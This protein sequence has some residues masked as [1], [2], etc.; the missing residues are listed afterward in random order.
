VSNPN[1]SAIFLSALMFL[2]ASASASPDRDSKQV[3]Q[4]RKANPCP[5]T[6]K[7]A[8][9]CPGWIVDH[10]TPLCAGGADHPDNMQWITREQAREKDPRDIRHCAALRRE[11]AAQRLH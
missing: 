9:A 6:G 8:G 7:I 5:A 2:V 4:F 11:K 3:H 1:K 10:R